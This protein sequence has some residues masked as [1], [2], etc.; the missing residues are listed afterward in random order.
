MGV[1]DGGLL[2]TYWQKFKCVVTAS[3]VTGVDDGVPINY[4]LAK[5]QVRGTDSLHHT[6]EH[7]NVDI[8]M[9]KT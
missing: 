3:Y 8:G 7:E 5:I 1:D 9:K 2:T 4:L 6:N